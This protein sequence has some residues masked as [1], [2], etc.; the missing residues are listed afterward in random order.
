MARPTNLRLLTDFFNKIGQEETS[1]PWFVRKG[2]DNV[3]CDLRGEWLSDEN[4]SSI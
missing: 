4:A 3:R 2:A 1:L